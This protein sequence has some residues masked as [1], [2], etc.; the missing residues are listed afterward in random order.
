M[1]A[2]DRYLGPFD[3]P[4]DLGLS[5]GQGLIGPNLRLANSAARTHDVVVGCARRDTL[6]S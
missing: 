1:S 2:V 4:V 5:A 3:R 6:H